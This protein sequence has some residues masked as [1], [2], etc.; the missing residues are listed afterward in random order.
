[1]REIRR[2]LGPQEKQGALV[3]E[4][5]R[6]RGR[7]PQEYLSLCRGVLSEGG[8][9]PLVWATGGGTSCIG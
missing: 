2:G 8:K 5:K 3:A 7:Q 9:V 6:R 1:M 4:V